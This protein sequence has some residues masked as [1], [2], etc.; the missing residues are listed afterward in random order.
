[1]DEPRSRTE[2]RHGTPL[3]GAAHGYARQGW[4]VFPCHFPSAGG[5]SCTAPDCSSPAKHPLTSHGLH[6]ASTRHGVIDR[7]WT[8]WPHAN[9]AIRTGKVSGLVVIDVDPAH[10]GSDSITKLINDHGPFPHT[11]TVHTGGG[12]LHLYF[13]HP[14][15]EI[16]NSSGTAVG[17]GIDVRG[18]GG[19]VLAPPSVHILGARYQ[20]ARTARLAPLPD[21]L[22]THL[23]RPNEPDAGRV[24]AVIRADSNPSSWARAALDGEVARV[25]AAPVGRRNHTLNR[26]AFVLGQIVGGGHLDRDHV[27]DALAIAATDAGLSERESSRTIASGMRA[28]EAQPRT[29]SSLSRSRENPFVGEADATESHLPPSPDLRTIDLPTLQAGQAADLPRDPSVEVSL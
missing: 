19:Y 22:L 27:I 1:M 24:A 20:W 12:G 5:C 11:T 2:S 29:P 18:D 6:D 7:W 14:G 25:Q 9:V 4:A 16:R 15:N 17:A 3:A 8:R 28:G 21:W 26:S 10:G 13:R 23:E